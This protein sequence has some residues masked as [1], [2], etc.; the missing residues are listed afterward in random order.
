MLEV[1]EIKARPVGFAVFENPLL[2]ALADQIILLDN[3]FRKHSIAAEN[4]VRSAFGTRYRLGELIHLNYDQIVEECGSQRGFAEK[5]GKSEAQIS[6][7]LRGYRNLLEAGANNL[8]EALQLLNGRNIRPTSQNFE[9]IGRLL[10]EPTAETTQV[11]QIDKDERRLLELQAEAEEI[12]RRNER[13]SSPV[14]QETAHMMSFLNDMSN[15]LDE[16]DIF[17]REFKS[18]RYLDF[19][20]TYGIDIITREP[21]ARCDPH[22]TN[23]TGGSGGMGMK[24]PDWMTIPVSRDTHEAIEAGAMLLTERDIARA[25]IEVMATFIVNLY[26]KHEE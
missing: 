13:S 15:H 6:N 3:E 19:V 17:S 9:K 21:V 18:E 14:L 23:L 22:H 20:R 5:I 10:N 8:E 24:V 2:N 25:L 12:L 4:A 11:E 7:A 26:G 16:Q 1:A